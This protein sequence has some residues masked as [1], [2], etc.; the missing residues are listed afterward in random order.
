MAL[1]PETHPWPVMKH[2][3][4]KLLILL[5]AH[6]ALAAQDIPTGWNMIS[7][8][9]IK[10][11]T[12]DGDTF[13]ADLNRNGRIAGKQERVR[14]LYVDTP[15]LNESHKGK[16]LKHG[17]PARG[18]LEN[19]LASGDCRLWVD[20]ENSIGNRG[21]L[22][23]LLEC[24]K[25]NIS[26]ELITQGHSYFDTRFSQPRDYVLYARQ[27]ARAFNARL[28]IWS[29][30]DSRNA[31][32]KR[33][34]DEGK[35]VYSLKNPLFKVQPKESLSLQPAVHEGRFL[36]VR[37]R[38]ET[39]RDLS[40]GAR[41]IFLQNRFLKPGLPVITFPKQRKA[42]RM[43]NLRVKTRIQVE[44]FVQL[45]RGKQWQIRFHRGMVLN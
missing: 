23:G 41:L 13:E 6:S 37:G 43:E 40:R 19:K 30:T 26:L 28:G 2:Y 35:T 24:A 32:L 3:I 33:L 39:I 16:D 45:Y 18:F 7:L 34:R 12:I 22:L 36:R 38:V 21:R 8:K 1:H 15:E 4:L 11:R 42:S 10:L 31:Y 44:G 14:L 9:D 5:H 20:P 17:I 25:T 29:R 27:E